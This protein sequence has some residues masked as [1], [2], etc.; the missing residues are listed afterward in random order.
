MGQERTQYLGFAQ[1]QTVR[2][3]MLTFRTVRTERIH[4]WLVSQRQ[5]PEVSLRKKLE[6]E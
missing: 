2:I 1:L 6:E 3:A 4:L 5:W